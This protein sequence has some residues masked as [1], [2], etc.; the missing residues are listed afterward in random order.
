MIQDKS[1]I[2]FLNYFFA[3][4]LNYSLSFIFLLLLKYY[5]NHKCSFRP[6]TILS[7]SSNSSKVRKSSY[8]LISS[9]QTL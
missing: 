3:S 1:K 6:L 5:G 9:L 8:S 2:K 7:K 4:G